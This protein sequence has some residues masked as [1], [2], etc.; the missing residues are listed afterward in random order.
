MGMYKALIYNRNVATSVTAQGRQFISTAGMFFEQFLADNAKFG[1][2]DE[3]AVFIR[4]I[5]IMKK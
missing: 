3:V 1:S 5:I 4:N 2:V